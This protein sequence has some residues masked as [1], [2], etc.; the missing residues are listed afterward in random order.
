M[1]FSLQDVKKSVQR[2][3][4]ELSVS[5]H[6]LRPGEL[7]EEIARLIAYHEELLGQPQRNFSLD[8]ARSYIGD[9]RLAHCL[10]ATLSH[11]YSWQQREWAAVLQILT[12]SPDLADIT[13]SVQLRLAL[14]NYVNQQHQG[15]LG[16]QE[17]AG[18]LQAFAANYQLAVADLEYLL[19]L[20]SEEEALLSRATPQ[21]PN[22]Q[23]VATL[24]NQWVF[25]AALFNASGVSFVIDCQ[26]F[27]KKAGQAATGAV[28]MGVGAVIKRLSY[29]ARKLGVY[30]DLTYDAAFPGE[31][32]ALE[33][34]GAT[35][36]LLTLTLY[37][38]Q[39]VTGAPQHYGLRLAR[40]CRLLLGYGVA[41]AERGH[42]R[43][44]GRTLL[45]S[46]IVEAA[47]KIH[48][49]QRAYTFAMDSHVLKF[50]ESPGEESAQNDLTAASQATATLFDSSIEQSFSEAFQSLAG[51]WGMDGWELEREPEPLLLPQSIFIPDF[52]LSR[53][54]R[55]IYVEILGFWTPAYRE[56][57]IQ[58]LQQ[59]R[60]RDD[61]L[62]AIPVEAKEAFVSIAQDFP[63]VFYQD[64]LSATD[65]LQV[66]RSRYDDFAER[67]ARIDVP[68]VREQ[69]R[70]EGLLSE[71]ASYQA[72]CCYRRSEL[73]RAA[74]L[75]VDE[76]IAFLPGIGLYHLNWIEQLK[77]TFLAWMHE[78]QSASLSQVLYELKSRNQA[79][80]VCEDTT[81]EALLNLWPEVQIRRD[82]IFDVQVELVE[83]VDSSDEIAQDAQPVAVSGPPGAAENG[84][85]R[86]G[87][88]RAVKKRVIKERS[89]FQEDLWG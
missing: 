51:G 48:F 85:K 5:L 89:A 80:Q 24:Y 73:Q 44:K 4:G 32:T 2:R 77:Q 7:Q 14:Y 27:S 31:K 54:N 69:V 88:R 1:R 21:A 12:V 66:L 36:P 19:A 56:R 13:S 30:Y 60:G 52:A 33:L 82:S 63:I 47:A 15:F 57:K 26:A 29:L 76:E 83:N 42:A 49:L 10:I 58:K 35:A 39:E 78:Q 40:L 61:L 28:G 9:Y 18:A 11:W 43:N 65:V 45:A 23:D 67:L 75:I 37:G 8:D 20:D 74:E 87:E 22:V 41:H 25:E 38:P 79:L 81:I 59:L 64:Q 62:L 86:T 84:G 55:R 46:A 3:D 70:R 6:F 17:R 34:P 68:I 71:K 53:A 72:L 50:I 16:E